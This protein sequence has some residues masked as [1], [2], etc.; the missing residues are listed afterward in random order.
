[1]LTLNFFKNKRV[2]IP[3]ILVALIG[4][5]NVFLTSTTNVMASHE[6]TLSDVTSLSYASAEDYEWQAYVP[7]PN[8]TGW[9]NFWARVGNFFNNVWNEIVDFFSDWE[10]VQVR[11]KDGNVISIGFRKSYEWN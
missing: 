1:M 4:T 9:Q 10:V 8:K 3:I 6:V 2:F 7:D 5:A 11:D